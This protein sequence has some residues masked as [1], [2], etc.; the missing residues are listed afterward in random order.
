MPRLVLSALN[1]KS[2]ASGH[3]AQ[4]ITPVSRLKLSGLGASLVATRKFVRMTEPSL[5]GH[6]IKFVRTRT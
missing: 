1:N 5:F 3:S 4:H 6:V 2:V